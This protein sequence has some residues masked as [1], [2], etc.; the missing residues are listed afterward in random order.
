[1]LRDWLNP[2]A[3]KPKYYDNIMAKRPQHFVAAV[4][5]RYVQYKWLLLWPAFTITFE[6]L[7]SKNIMTLPMLKLFSL[8]LATNLT[9]GVF[10]AGFLTALFCLGLLKTYRVAKS[11]YLL[12][13]DFT[14]CQQLT[15]DI[16][17]PLAPRYGV[18]EALAF[19]RFT[20]AEIVGT[21]ALAGICYCAG[22]TGF[23]SANSIVAVGTLGLFSMAIPPVAAGLLFAATAALASLLTLWAIKEAHAEDHL[24]KYFDPI[25]SFLF[26]NPSPSAEITVKSNHTPLR[27]PGPGP[28]NSTPSSERN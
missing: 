20:D 16:H 23:V 21:L 2:K 25:R 22:L 1:M 24:C 8:T 13:R 3:P 4:R 5:S 28:V 9:G 27:L 7:V 19:V 10:L 26:Q 18:K 14:D 11:H 12:K 17:N 6:I 15:E